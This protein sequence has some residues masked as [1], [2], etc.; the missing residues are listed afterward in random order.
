[1]STLVKTDSF[2]GQYTSPMP[3]KSAKA[4]QSDE[5]S[6]FTLQ[7]QRNLYEF[8]RRLLVKRLKVPLAL[9]PRVSATLFVSIPLFWSSLRKQASISWIGT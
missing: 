4:G 2:E 8:M 6:E 7:Q 1:M 3:T 5:S 9:F